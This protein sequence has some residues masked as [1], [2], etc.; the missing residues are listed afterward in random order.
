MY[1]SELHAEL[2]HVDRAG[3]ISYLQTPLTTMWRVEGRP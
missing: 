1:A 3:V 2:R